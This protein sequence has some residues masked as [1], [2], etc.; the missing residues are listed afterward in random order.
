M[1]LRFFRTPTELRKWLDQHHA[2]AD[3]L[4]VGYYK[5]GSGKPSI[6][7]P[8]SVDEALC[9][10]WIDGIRKSIDDVSYKIRFTP[11]RPG[12]NWSKV[13]VEKAEVLVEQGRMQPPGLVAFEIRKASKTGSYSYERRRVELDE[14]YNR[15]LKK[16]KAAWDFYQAQSP[17]YRKT[18]NWWIASAKKEETRQRRLEKLIKYSSLGEKIPEVIPRKRSS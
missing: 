12:S 16:N 9:Y 11:R 10:G 14:P 8:E 5:K 18:V 17:Y 4:W 15:T 7:W 13:N 6:D 2:S 1:T 3:E